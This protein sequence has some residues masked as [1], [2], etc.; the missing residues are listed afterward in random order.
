M[1]RCHLCLA[2]SLLLLAASPLHALDF[3]QGEFEGALTNKLSMGASWRT[4]SR[5]PDLVSLANGGQAFSSNGDDGNLA[6]DSGDVVAAALK[7]TSDLSLRWKDYGLF[8]R[9]SGLVNP[10]ILHKDDIFNI[11]DYGAGKEADATLADFNAK[12]DAV[13][14]QVGKRYDVLD[15]YV[16][17][18][19][20]IGP[21]TLVAK[22]G[23][24]SLNWGESTLVLHGLNSIQAFDINRLRV[25][26]FELE[27]LARPAGMAWVSM[28]ISE[29]ISADAF[30]QFEW[31]KTVIDAS[32]TF[33]STNDF[34]GP[35]GTQANLGF[36]RVNENSPAFTTCTDASNCVPLG[37]TVPRGRDVDADDGGQYGGVLHFLVAPLNDMD[38]AFYAANYHSRLPLFSGTSRSGGGL[39]PADTSNYFVEYPEDIGLFGVSF[40]TTVPFDL[41]LQGEYSLKVDQPLQVDDVELLLAGLGAAGQISPVPGATLGNQVIRGFRRFEVSQ[42]D[43]SATRIFSPTVAFDQ[44]S[45]LVEFGAVLVHDLPEPET[46][47]FEAPATY[48]LN[49]G[50]AAQNPGTAAGLPIT[51]YG[52]YATEFSWGYRVL[53]R[54]TYNNVFNLFNLEPTLIW[55]HDL[56]GTTPTPITNFIEDRQQLTALLG[57]TYLSDWGFGLGYTT[58]FGA[59]RRNLL[60]DRDFAEINLKYSF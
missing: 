23:R 12:T 8:L 19:F 55:Q 45:L 40:N 4:Q 30:Y 5:D 28:D 35:A 58:Y 22:V 25:P 51:P 39:T 52:D 47:A 49:P 20:A 27:E 1:T 46:L 14:D 7:L 24:Q 41:A 10:V 6:F 50:T 57:A 21:R 11:G 42:W 43:L 2:L 37:S 54:F 59:G 56:E 48:T 32:G 29:G 38:L 9:G 34:A 44:L 26:G 15:A 16:S 31:R 60:N 18:T 3:K 17:G 33:F 13:R 53:S 36:G